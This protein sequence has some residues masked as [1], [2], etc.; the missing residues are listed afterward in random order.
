MAAISSSWLVNQLPLISL[1]PIDIPVWVVISVGFLIFV[2]LTFIEKMAESNSFKEQV[3]PLKQAGISLT[4]SLLLGAV[5]FALS[6]NFSGPAQFVK[7]IQ[8]SSLFIILLG[9]TFAAIKLSVYVKEDPEEMHDALEESF[10]NAQLLTLKMHQ[11]VAN[12]IAELTNSQI[13]QEYCRRNLGRNEGVLNR[14]TYLKS[15]FR[16][17]SEA[18]FFLDKL[19]KDKILSREVVQILFEDM[20]DLPDDLSE[21]QQIR[22]RFRMQ[23]NLA[24]R[25]LCIAV[26]FGRP[27]SLHKI[28]QTPIYHELL[29]DSKV[30]QSAF[31]LAGSRIELMA[32][33]EGLSIEAIVQIRHRL[34]DLVEAFENKRTAN[35]QRSPLIYSWIATAISLSSASS[36][37]DG[38]L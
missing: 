18:M 12:S 31:V 23:I 11:T 20:K 21:V 15:R 26:K 32:M 5:I 7:A 16:Y 3:E 27:N 13:L 37:I 4:I 24:L 33:Q 35:F 22:E 6:I 28:F 9:C 34:N 19:V 2:A 8:Y 29:F 38:K 30:Y 14:L 36:I 25:T 10:L 1:L 17:R